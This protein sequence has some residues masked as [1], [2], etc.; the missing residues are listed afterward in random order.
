[1]KNLFLL[2]IA[3]MGITSCKNDVKK[4]VFE[5]KDIFRSASII[6]DN[7]SNTLS[8]S[9]SVGG[10]W[11]LYAGHSD[12]K[13]DFSHPVAEGF[14]KGIF[15]LPVDNSVRNYFQLV[16][17]EG[18]AVIAEKHLPMEGGYNFRDLG[19]IKNKDGKY[20]RWGKIFRS[21]DLHNLTEA[22]L[23]YLASIPLI[24]IVDFRSE[25]EIKQAPDKNPET[26]VKNYAYSIDPGNLTNANVFTDFSSNQGDSLMMEMNVLFATDS[27]YVSR[28]RDFFQ[29]LQDKK[30]VPLLFHCSAG[31][32]RTGMGA[33]L[34]LFA[35]GVDKET[36]IQD[37]LSSNTYLRDKYAKYIEEYPELKSLFS[38]KPE[39]L[40]AGI[41]RIVEDH[42]T[43]ENYL[44]NVLNV[45]IEKF[46]EMYLY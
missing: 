39:Y 31:K 22:D 8:L 12:E 38:V 45:D 25:N 10:A 35:L 41:D 3:C 16:T 5:G 20:V 43:V 15:L 1:M 33:A 17:D 37:Y 28:Y 9:I 14:G 32:D 27:V 30:N 19:G 29:L 4:G 40:S 18:K 34:I 13:I 6:R 7:N 44:R 23:K 26:V 21:D 11:K 2:I 46:R 36:I 24:S 42:E